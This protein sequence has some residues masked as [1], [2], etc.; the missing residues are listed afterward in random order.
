MNVLKVMGHIAVLI[1]FYLIGSWIQELFHLFIPGSI[2][3]ML[4]LFV[5]LLT[6]KVNVNWVNEGA[7]L[8][9]RHLALL[10]VPVTVGI[11]QYLELFA[12]KSFFLIPIALCST[13]LV[14]VCSGMVSQYIVRQK[15][16]EY[17]HFNRD[18]HVH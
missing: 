4:L 14:M 2:I 17:E 5:T 6:K 7:D 15:E 9:I 10:F 13:L 1:L 3:G 12:G 18:H 11:I 16:R 8:L